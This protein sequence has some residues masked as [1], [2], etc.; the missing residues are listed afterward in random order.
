MYRN[1][2]E[3]NE[4]QIRQEEKRLFLLQLD[5]FVILLVI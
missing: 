2:Y 1:D 4:L 3:Q 5:N